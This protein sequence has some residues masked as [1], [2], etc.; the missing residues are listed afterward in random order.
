LPQPTQLLSIAAT[1]SSFSGSS[2]CLTE[3]DGLALAV[4]DR[5]LEQRF[6]P[7]LLVEHALR[8]GDDH[9]RAALLGGERIAQDVAHPAHVIGAVEMAHPFDAHA[10]HRADDRVVG[11]A[12]R[13]ERAR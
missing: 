1:G 12:C 2:V 13:V 3:S 7:A 9:F 11:G 5:L 6:H 4:A 8:G 10:L